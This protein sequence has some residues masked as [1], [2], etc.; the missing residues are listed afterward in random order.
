M[1]SHTFRTLRESLE[2]SVRELAGLLHIKEQSIRNIESG[3]A[4]PG[5]QVAL[6]L[7][8]LAYPQV[9]RLAEHF[10]ATDTL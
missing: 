3:S 9:R 2:L 8:L 1:E 4:R 7:H 5:P 10:R 6:L